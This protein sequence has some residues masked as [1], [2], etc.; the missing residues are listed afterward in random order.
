MGLGDE[1]GAEG[2]RADRL[3]AEVVGLPRFQRIGVGEAAGTL[4]PERDEVR[5][6]LDA[7]GLGIRR[8]PG[9][10]AVAEAGPDPPYGVQSRKTAPADP[11]TASSPSDLTPL[12][13]TDLTELA[14]MTR[15]SASNAVAR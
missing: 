4:V 13:I 8:G 11:P 9:D 6:A 15:S 14:A 1:E 12:A 7:G 2:R 10:L 3:D 5:I